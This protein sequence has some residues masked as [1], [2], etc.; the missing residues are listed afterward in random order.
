MIE[1]ERRR[2]HGPDHSPLR[3][4]QL[5]RLRGAAGP[6][7]PAGRACGRLRGPLLPPRHHPGQERAGQEIRRPDGGDHLAGEEEVPGTGAAAA[8]PRPV[9]ADLQ[10]GQRHLRPVHG[11]GGALRH[12]RELAG[13]HPHPP[14]AG[15]GRPGRGGPAAGADEAGDGADPLRGGLLQQGVR[16]AG[17]RL[18]KARR[19]H[20][21]LPGELAGHRLA[22]AGG[23][24]AVCGRRGAEAARPVRHPAPS[25]SWPPAKKRPWRP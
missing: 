24:A 7:G 21:H 23:G 14:P 5:L 18:Q 12:R 11:S 17:Q 8:S 20:R 4:Q 1:A 2:G 16:Q 9:P 19:H 15:R 13:H 25:G 22:A 3:S 6:A 10:T